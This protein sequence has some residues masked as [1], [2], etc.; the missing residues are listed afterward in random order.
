MI[1]VNPASLSGQQTHRGFLGTVKAFFRILIL[2]MRLCSSAGFPPVPTLPTCFPGPLPRAFLAFVSFNHPS[3]RWSRLSQDER[4]MLSQQKIY[5]KQ[6]D[7]GQAT[8]RGCN[9][10]GQAAQGV[11]MATQDIWGRDLVAMTLLYKDSS[12]HKTLKVTTDAICHSAM[13]AQVTSVPNLSCSLDA[14]PT[15]I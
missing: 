10:W 2:P 6:A 7:R 9:H 14:K 1:Y 3:A 5:C 4:K 15:K 13:H 11:V 12:C 8:V